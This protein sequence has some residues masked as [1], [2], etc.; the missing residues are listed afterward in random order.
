MDQWIACIS[1]DL[2]NCAFLTM[3]RSTS[4]TDREGI[5]RC[6][7]RHRRTRKICSFLAVGREWRGHSPFIREKAPRFVVNDYNGFYHCFSTG[8]HGDVFCFLLETEGLSLR[9][10]CS[11]SYV[12]SQP[13]AS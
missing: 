6:L 1:K 9:G 7:P 5:L 3:V 8:K 13:A 11:S 2:L 4:T 10:G 12:R